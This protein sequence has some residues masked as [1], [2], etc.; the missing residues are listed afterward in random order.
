M[1]IGIRPTNDYAFKKTFGVQANELAL[2]SLLNAIL[3]L[4]RP[5]QSVTI[6][7]PF[8]LQDFEE[9]KLSILDVLA[10]DAAGAH[11]HIEVQLSLLPGLIQ[12]IVYY[13]CDTYAAQLSKGDQYLSL[14]PVYSICLLDGSLWRDSAQLHHIFRLT[15][16]QSGR[17]L[18][19]TIEIHFLELGKYTLQES[20]LATASEQDRWLFWLLHAHEY[21]PERLL[22]LLPQTG[23][24]QATGTLIE[25]QGKT[26]DRMRYDA[27]EK[28]L[29]DQQWAIAAAHQAGEQ[30]GIEKGIEKGVEKGKTEGKAEGKAEGK[31]ELIRV[32]E[33][34][35]SAPAMDESELSSKSLDELSQIAGQLQRMLRGRSN[36]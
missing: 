23:F 10:Q 4:P 16:Q 25:I 2:V 11:Y 3:D 17:E 5:I 8:S 1:P 20:E 18:D 22:E 15:D 33:D 35:L 31:I 21:E 34:L 36:S 27:R 9:D 14:T 26:E 12:R 28:A 13:T 7:N 19:G 30:E 29:R 24:Q 32:L 6:R